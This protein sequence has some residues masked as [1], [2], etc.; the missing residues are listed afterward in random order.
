[1]INK[2][3]ILAVVP[4]RSRSKGLKNKNFKVLGGKPLFIHPLL[5]LKKS[6]YVDKIV[7]STDSDKIIKISKKYGSF[8]FL[9]DQNNSRKINLL[10][11]KF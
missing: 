9:K 10:H 6:K 8:V 1:M 3:R 5:A 2:K 11:L 7:L 4:A